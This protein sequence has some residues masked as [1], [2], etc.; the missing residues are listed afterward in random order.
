MYI[1]TP[2]LYHYGLVQG[3][4]PPS[5]TIQS[6]GFDFVT[7]T[8][9]LVLSTT[10]TPG[11]ATPPSSTHSSPQSHKPH[12]KR[13]ATLGTKPGSNS[14]TRKHVTQPGQNSKGRKQIAP[15]E[16]RPSSEVPAPMPI[17]VPGSASDVHLRLKKK[18]QDRIS[19]QIRSLTSK[20]VEAHASRDAE[21]AVLAA[22]HA[23]ALA[24]FI[25]RFP[26]DIPG[27]GP[28]P[29]NLPRDGLETV[30]VDL[31]DPNKHV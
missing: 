24:E 3:F 16:L 5:L 8:R 30:S 21:E 15:A 26:V 28:C 13:T 1:G 10:P 9:P 11:T 19:R 4:N 31:I 23:E 18:L 6:T 7:G 25:D 22:A 29:P 2:F 27:I 12:N 14:G 17:P 20:E